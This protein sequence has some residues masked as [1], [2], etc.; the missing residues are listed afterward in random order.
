M[1]Q[2]Q[3]NCAE[4][5]VRGQIC[6]PQGRLDGP[7]KLRISSLRDCAIT[8]IQ[9]DICPTFLKIL[10]HLLAVLECF[11]NYDC[12]CVFAYFLYGFPAVCLGNN[13]A[14]YYGLVLFSHFLYLDPFSWIIKCL[15]MGDVKTNWE[16]HV[17]QPQHSASWLCSNS[18]SSSN[19]SVETKPLRT[20]VRGEGA[21]ASLV[22]YVEWKRCQ[23]KCVLGKKIARQTERNVLE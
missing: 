9:C 10:L 16:L 23:E 17:S 8:A 22:I 21:C 19:K 4:S 14:S 11:L 18:P 1:M 7:N 5:H 2:R 20:A 3:W 13:I 12:A 6:S 15:K